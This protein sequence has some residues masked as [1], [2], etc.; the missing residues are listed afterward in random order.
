MSCYRYLD[1]L[2]VSLELQIEIFTG[3]LVIQDWNL[4]DGRASE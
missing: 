3:E 4:R 2:V 1:L